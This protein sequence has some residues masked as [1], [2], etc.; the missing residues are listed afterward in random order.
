MEQMLPIREVT[1][2]PPPSPPPP[3]P[4]ND[5]HQT[6]V[7]SFGKGRSEKSPFLVGGTIFV[8]NLA[9]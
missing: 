6:Y 7:T 3:P 1:A 4:A 5:P 2:P 9:V 8:C